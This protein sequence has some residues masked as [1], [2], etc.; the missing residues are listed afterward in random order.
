MQSLASLKKVTARLAT[1]EQAHLYVADAARLGFRPGQV[2]SRL[3]TDLGNRRSL[4][5][6]GVENG[7][8]SYEQIKVRRAPRIQL[9][10]RIALA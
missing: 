4:M 8:A 9:R 10:V 5:L 2:P 6:S 1:E 7:I 3:L